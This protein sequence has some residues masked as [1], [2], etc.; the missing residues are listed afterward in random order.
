[1]RL[2]A[3]KVGPIKLSTEQKPDIGWNHVVRGGR[4][5]KA[6]AS[7]KQTPTSSDA[8]E[9]TEFNAA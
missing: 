9:R 3:T 8:G 6:Q 1:M 4:E 7:P 2:T 5:I